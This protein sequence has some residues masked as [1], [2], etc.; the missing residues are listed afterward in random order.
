[1]AL[2][3]L[4]LLPPLWKS[5]VFGEDLPGGVETPDTERL[6]FIGDVI[7]NLG[8]TS[9][10]HDR[11]PKHH[12]HS[13]RAKL[14]DISS[15][16]PGEWAKLYKLPSHVVVTLSGPDESKTQPISK[17]DL[18]RAYV[19]AVYLDGGGE[20][21]GGVITSGWIKQ[22]ME[23]EEQEGRGSSESDSD[24]STEGDVTEIREKDRDGI[25]GMLNALLIPSE[26]PKQKPAAQLRVNT[27]ESNSRN[28]LSLLN[29]KAIQKRSMLAWDD[30]PTGPD[31]AKTW[32]A[33]LTVEGQEF[34]GAG[35]NKKQAKSAASEVA[36]KALKWI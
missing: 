18:F 29:E 24:D 31:H 36:L 1:M 13:L 9:W 16:K 8:I 32:E 10:L 21:G 23:F 26:P 15:K 22:I 3:P 7:V 19:G 14:M 34:V 20:R 33:K 30:R 2:P 6:A 35:H 5:R 4:P 27:P 12:N 25:G 17:G 28:F 11:Y